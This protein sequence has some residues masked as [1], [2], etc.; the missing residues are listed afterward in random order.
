[1]R[2]FL[3]STV[4]AKAG[5]SSSSPGSAPARGSGQGCQR[6]RSTTGGCSAASDVI[7]PMDVEVDANGFISVADRGAEEAGH[8]RIVKFAP[9]P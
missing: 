2:S 9:I 8:K 1:M 7:A 3:G 4:A 6:R 5:L